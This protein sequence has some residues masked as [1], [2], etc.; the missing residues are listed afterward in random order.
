MTEIGVG[1]VGMGTVGEGACGILTRNVESIARQAGCQ[2]RSPAS[3]ICGGMNCEA[4]CPPKCA[5]SMMRVHSQPRRADCLRADRRN[6]RGGRSGAAGDGRRKHVVTANKEL[7]AKHGP[8]LLS[9]ADQQAW[10]STSRRAWAAESRS[11]AAAHRPCRKPHPEDRR[12]RQRH[13][14]LHSHPDGRRRRDLVGVLKEAQGL[15]YAEADPTTMSR[16]T[17]PAT[18]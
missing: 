3:P 17:T 12:H 10:T 2:V 1:I 4:G 9:L 5:L 7:L 13:H 8:E 15:G 16:A 18:S 14:E 6:P 11:S